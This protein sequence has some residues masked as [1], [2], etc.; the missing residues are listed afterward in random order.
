MRRLLIFCCCFFFCFD[1]VLGI[2][3]VNES[4][5]FG[6]SNPVFLSGESEVF[7]FSSINLNFSSPQNLFL[8]GKNREFL[9]VI[10]EGFLSS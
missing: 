8:G 2:G 1:L 5:S 10:N 7:G 9:S 4:L 6:S 3:L